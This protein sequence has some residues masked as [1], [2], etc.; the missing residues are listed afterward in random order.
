MSSAFVKELGNT[1]RQLGKSIDTV[2]VSIMGKSAHIEKCE[3]HIALSR[4]LLSMGRE[5]T[6]L[7][8][9]GL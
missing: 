4:L 7:R 5:R 1:V 6:M 9:C 8:L 2:G 3:F